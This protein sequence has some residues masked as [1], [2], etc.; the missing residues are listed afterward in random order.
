M[1]NILNFSA[2]TAFGS[3]TYEEITLAKA[4]ELLLK[5]GFISAISHEGNATLLSQLMGFEIAFNRIE[6]RQQKEETA[7]VFKIK[8]TSSR[9]GC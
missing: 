7:L 2:L 3:Y 6:Y 4:R 8:K 5:E 9:T 1:I